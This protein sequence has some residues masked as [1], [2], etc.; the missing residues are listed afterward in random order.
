VYSL[1]F[2]LL[3]P[4][5]V[6]FSQLLTELKNL[7]VVAVVVLQTEALIEIFC[8]PSVGGRRFA[9]FDSAQGCM[10]IVLGRTRVR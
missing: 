5:G 2:F 4:S 6:L 8:F 10:C 1:I 3:A 9:D 7:V